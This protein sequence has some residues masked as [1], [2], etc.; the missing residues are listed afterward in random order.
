MLNSAVSLRMLFLTDRKKLEQ[1]DSPD[2]LTP[3]QGLLKILL[4]FSK[5]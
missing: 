3:M 5:R 1:F 2:H 4:N